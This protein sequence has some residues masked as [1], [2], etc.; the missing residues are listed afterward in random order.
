MTRSVVRRQ[1]DGNPLRYRASKAEGLVLSRTTASCGNNEEGLR[2]RA[3]ARQKENFITKEIR[4][5]LAC[6]LRL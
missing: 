6:S 3:Q 1:E 5:A 2:V 4:N